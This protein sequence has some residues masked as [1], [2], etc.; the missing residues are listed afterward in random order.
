[1]NH[2]IQPEAV[3]GG[4]LVGGVMIFGI[5]LA[6]VTM[7]LLIWSLI[8][9]YRDAETRGKSGVAVA[10]LVFLVGWPMSLLAWLV[11]RPEFYHRQVMPS[12]PPPMPKP[13]PL[14]KSSRVEES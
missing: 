9:V 11:F 12:L 3:A 1:M 2:D 13:D 6:M 8:W 5:L 7:G 10:L 4:L 14:L